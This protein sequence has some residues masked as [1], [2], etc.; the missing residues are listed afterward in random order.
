MEEVEA[1]GKVPLGDFLE[2]E[3]PEF[4]EEVRRMN[5]RAKE[6]RSNGGER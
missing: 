4:I 3:K 2:I 1:Q 5:Q 6:A